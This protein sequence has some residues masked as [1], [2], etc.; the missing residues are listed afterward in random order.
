ML[1][2]PGIE[3]T[4]ERGG[5]GTA[6]TQVRRGGK[7]GAKVRGGARSKKEEREERGA[8][9]DDVN[10]RE[11]DGGVNEKISATMAAMEEGRE[12]TKCEIAVAVAMGV[13]TREGGEVVVGGQADIGDHR[14]HRRTRRKK[15]EKGDP[16]KTTATDVAQTIAAIDEHV[17][18]DGADNPAIV[19]MIIL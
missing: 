8:I 6:R 15:V 7:N 1:D 14:C 10:R 12:S 19:A 5:G 9:A 3:L 4:W 13:V 2:S 16:A 11:W 18:R 17:Q